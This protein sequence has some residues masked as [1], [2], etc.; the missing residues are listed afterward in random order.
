MKLSAGH[1][2]FLFLALTLTVVVLCTLP[3]LFIKKEKLYIYTNMNQISATEQSFMK[4]LKQLGVKVIVNSKKEITENDDVLWLSTENIYEKVRKSK[5]RNNFIYSENY[6]P[7]EWQ[8]LN[9]P[10]IIL[11]P[12]Q[13]LYEHYM[14]S[15]VPSAKMQLGVDMS[16]FYMKKKKKKY[17]VLYYGDNTK[18]LQHIN[19]LKNEEHICF[20]GISELSQRDACVLSS[21]DEK[22][23]SNILSESEIVITYHNPQEKESQKIPM[24]IME[25][26]ASGA[27]VFSSPNKT[28][29]KIYGTSI[30]IYNNE[31]ELREKLKYY[32]SHPNKKSPNIMASKITAERLSSKSSAQ[33]FYKIWN[34]VKENQKL[35]SA[36]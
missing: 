16:I 15:N 20:M 18:N 1:K 33:R 29:Q 2:I 8:E 27:I 21:N 12:Y 23:R 6:Y 19:L 9:K 28:V 26:A 4:E 34:W 10:V 25:A 36:D 35:N 3:F 11:T 30:I 31:Y 13:L 5:S 14:R 32:S 17:P 24:D 22:D 7:L